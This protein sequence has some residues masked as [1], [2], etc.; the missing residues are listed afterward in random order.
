M[1]T[2]RLAPTAADSVRTEQAAAE[3][4]PSNYEAGLFEEYC[5]VVET[6]EPLSKEALVYADSYHKQPDSSFDIQV[7]RLGD[8]SPLLGAT[9]LS[10]SNGRGSAE[11]PAFVN[12]CRYDSKSV[13][14]L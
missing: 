3:L 7:A 8:G 12:S 2:P 6:G 5:Q 11:E 10:V 1:S 13:V 4:L 9:S 14:P